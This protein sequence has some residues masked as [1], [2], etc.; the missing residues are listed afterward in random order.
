MKAW[1]SKAAVQLREQTDDCFPDRKRA[2]DGWI[3]DARHSARVSDHNPN[4]Q[5]EVCAI[6]ID[7]RLSDQEGVSFD[8]ADQIRQ[9]AKIDK[10]ISYIIHAGKI[11]SGKSLGRWV[12]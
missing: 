5:G 7:A 6:D 11:C 8:L 3:G 10:R 4:E 9:A 1:L 2:S 12:K